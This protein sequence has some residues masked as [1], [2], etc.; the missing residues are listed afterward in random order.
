MPCIQA[1]QTAIDQKGF[2]YSTKNYKAPPQKVSSLSFIRI[3]AA[4]AIGLL[5]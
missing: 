2:G 3:N 5:S 1:F 4:R